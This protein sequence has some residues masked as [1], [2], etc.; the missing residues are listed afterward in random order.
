MG[1]LKNRDLA[2]LALLLL[3]ASAADPSIDGPRMTVCG[4]LQQQ[5]SLPVY[6]SV[7]S[8]CG[9]ERSTVGGQVATITGW[10]YVDEIP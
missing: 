5:T 1:C 7:Q 2:V 6:T 3:L 10:S 8:W 9:A 4:F